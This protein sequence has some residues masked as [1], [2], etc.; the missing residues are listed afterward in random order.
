MDRTRKFVG[1]FSTGCHEPIHDRAV[2]RHDL[3]MQSPDTPSTDHEPWDEAPKRAALA[4]AA[5]VLFNADLS[6]R[7]AASLAA[8]LRPHAVEGAEDV[9]ALNFA[10]ARE[11][12]CRVA[13]R[14][15]TLLDTL[16]AATPVGGHLL[17]SHVHATTTGL[18]ENHLVQPQVQ[19]TLALRITS[20]LALR[21]LTVGDLLEATG[22][23]H[24]AIAVR[25]SRVT[26]AEAPDLLT[27]IAD[28]AH[29][30]HVVVSDGFTA[31]GDPALWEAACSLEVAH[32]TGATHTSSGP[33]APGAL[34]AAVTALRSS[35]RLAG[36]VQRGEFVVLPA[37]GA[38]LDL[39]PGAT[40]E[41]AG[42]GGPVRTRHLPG[43]YDEGFEPIV[44]ADQLG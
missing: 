21:D 22:A 34:A 32:V 1:R 31:P 37:T 17:S 4:R 42:P 39:P 6:G 16:G 9:A 27:A 30:G 11:E 18:A 43:A 25:C 20:P 7:P 36:P 29:A 28:N 23:V 40:A 3:V 5:N 26:L 13:G 2:S 41:A 15:V 38:W 24:T 33:I 19:A 35:V 8:A 44:R 14:V 10:R 12:G